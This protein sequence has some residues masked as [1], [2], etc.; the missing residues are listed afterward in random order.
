MREDWVIGP[1]RREVVARTAIGRVAMDRSLYCMASFV[2]V[3]DV[4]DVYLFYCR[5]CLL[6][7]FEY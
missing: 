3:D 5:C 2:S 6:L 7:C 4:V 1:P